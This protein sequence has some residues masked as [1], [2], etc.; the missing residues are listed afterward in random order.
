[1]PIS[2][3]NTL[4]RQL[5]EFKPLKGNTVRMYTCGPTVYAYAHIGNFR[6]FL[7]QD[8]L[9][10]YL[11]YAGFGIDHVINLTDVDDNTI[12]E[13]QAAKLPLR[14]YTEKYIE[15]FL[16][17]RHLLNLE[18]PEHLVRATDTIPE[19]LKLIQTLVDK[20]YA[21]ASD[22]SIYYKVSAFPAYGELAHIDFSGVRD[23]ARVDSDKY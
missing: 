6:T 3:Y 14:E 11:K 23:G 9:R 18:E 5:E 12:R 8:I 20:G 17:D 10:R 7:F 4:T 1:M 19:M 2:L 21:Y 15:A 16:A 22:G 13:S